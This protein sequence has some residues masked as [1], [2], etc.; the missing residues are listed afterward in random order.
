MS[1]VMERDY[2]DAE[3]GVL[4]RGIFADEEIYREELER[5]FARAWNFMCH[6]SQIPEPGDFFTNWIGEDEVIVVRGRDGAVRVLLNTC[7]HRGNKVCRAEIGNAQRFMCSYHGW[8]FHL[9]GS[10]AG[11]P[12]EDAFYRGGLDRQAWG[13]T[14]AAQVES[15]RGFVF[16]TLDANAPALSEYLGWVGRLGIDFMAS[17]GEVEFLDG[18]QKNRVRCNWKLAV[19]NIYDW[20]HVRVSHGASLRAGLFAEEFLGPMDQMV[21]LGEYGHGIGGPGI[22]ER[23]YAESVARLDAGERTEWYDAMVARRLRSPGCDGLGPV[24]VR[25]FG[26]PNIFPNLWVST[27]PQ[28]CLRIPRGPLET[29]LWW[30]TYQTKEMGERQRARNLYMANHYFGPAGLLEQDDAENWSHATLGARGTFARTLPSNLA[31]GKGA[32]R[33]LLDPSGQAR[34]ETVVNEHGQRWTYQSWQ[35]WMRAES[36]ADLVASHSMPP[37]GTL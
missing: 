25:S 13:M 4:D 29:E 15:Y 9:D 32:D 2:Y 27:S 24:G 16:A 6:E 18:V 7:P 28:V 5:I 23:Q 22:T 33:V 21:L 3:T 37:T 35:E 20:Y 11:M 17:L 19:D 10:L 34:V 8:N 1:A 14:P 30:F 31:M 12:G 26:H 36:W